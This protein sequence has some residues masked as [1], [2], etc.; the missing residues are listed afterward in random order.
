MSHLLQGGPHGLSPPS[1]EGSHLACEKSFPIRTKNLGPS[2][3]PV[4]T[5]PDNGDLSF[6]NRVQEWL[7]Y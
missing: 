7:T 6:G 1:G 2:G 4:K 5:L 3:C